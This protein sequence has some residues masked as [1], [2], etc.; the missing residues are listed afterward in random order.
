MKQIYALTITLLSVFLLFIGSSTLIAQPWQVTGTIQTENVNLNPEAEFNINE[1]LP[2]ITVRLFD[3]EVELDSDVTDVSGSY[4]LQHSV[5]EGELRIEATGPDAFQIRELT[6]IPTGD[7]HDE[8]PRSLFFVE[9][10]VFYQGVTYRTVQIGDQ[11]WMAENLRAPHYRNGDEIPNVTNNEAWA[12]LDSG[13]FAVHANDPVESAKAFNRGFLYNWF[14]VDDERGICPPGWGVPSDD[15]FKEMEE[16]LGMPAADLDLTNFTRGRVEGIGNKLRSTSGMDNNFYLHP[17]NMN[18]EPNNS[19]ATNETAFSARG[20]SIRFAGGGFGDPSSDFEGLGRVTHLWT[21]TENPGNSNNAFRRVLSVADGG[22]N[23][24]SPNKGLGLAV[25][26][27]QVEDDQSTSLEFDTEDGRGWRMMSVPFFGKTVAD[28]AAQN[29][30]SGVPGAN[31]FYGVDNMEEGVEA[32]L[33]FFDPALYD[34]TETETATGWVTPEDFNTEFVPGQGFIW[35]FF[36]NDESQSVPLDEF[37]LSLTGIAPSTDVDVPIEAGTWNL[38]GNPFPSN[39]SAASLSGAG[40]ESAAAQIWD[41]SEGTGSFITVEFSGTNTISAWQGLFI[42]SDDA[43]TFTFPESATTSD[44]ADFFSQD[45][46]ARMAFTLTG[47]DDESGVETVDKAISLLLNDQASTEWDK[48]D[49][50][51]LTPLTDTFA[52]LSFVDSQG[53]AEIFKAQKSQPFS[54]DESLELPMI[55]NLQ[56]ING[57]FTL[58]WDGITEFDDDITMNL[59]DQVTGETVNLRTTDSYTF[60]ATADE[61]VNQHRFTFTLGYT[62]TNTEAHPDLPQQLSLS[63]NYPNPFNPTTQINFDI[64]AESHVR[65]AVYDMLGRQVTV[66]VDEARNPGSYQVTWDASRFASGVYL[67]RLEAGGQ[68]ITNKMTLVK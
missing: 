51:K 57:S 31:A 66:L 45:N 52:T 13:A 49:I 2:G 25:R 17:R 6:G 23:R 54:F 50:R 46:E 18:E 28:L 15:D 56:N 44:P 62:A 7:D 59:V 12:D 8:G 61:A 63:Q 68:S 11:N 35:Y 4:T 48:R 33:S 53:D 16:F 24:N 1:P 29:E 42:H 21:S 3:G 64:P 39:I 41:S 55:L 22:I 9:G 19:S 10:S 58:E 27:I 20:T 30:V 34:P 47:L 36:D 60:E 67:Y 38:V 5:E 26:C 43:T 65:L 14:A 32:N 40:L 37:T